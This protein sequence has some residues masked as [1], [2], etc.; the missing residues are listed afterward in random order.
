[1]KRP[2]IDC[3]KC[4]GTGQAKLDD[5]HFESLKIIARRTSTTAVQLHEIQ[6]K[7]GE[8]ISTAHGRIG[9]LVEAGLIVGEKQGKLIKYRA[10]K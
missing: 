1:M 4:V 3:P 9:K 6:C 10:V 5:K 7:G 2:L 8:S